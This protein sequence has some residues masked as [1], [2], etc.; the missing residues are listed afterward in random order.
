MDNIKLLTGTNTFQDWYNKTNEIVGRINNINGD[1]ISVKDYG[2]KGDGIADDTTGISAAFTAA[3]GKV[4]YF[5]NGIYRLGVTGSPIDNLGRQIVKILTASTNI[6]GDNA[7]I[8]SGRTCA[9]MFHI[10]LDG[11]RYKNGRTAI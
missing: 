6:K 9:Q 7:T 1:L 5:P 8:I 11:K 4:L 10:V 2:A 3:M